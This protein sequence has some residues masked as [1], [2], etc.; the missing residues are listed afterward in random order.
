MDKK[1]VKLMLQSIRDTNAIGPKICDAEPGHSVIFIEEKKLV[2][3][4]N[5]GNFTLTKKG[6]RLLDGEL[7]WEDI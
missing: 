3:R 7:K 4:S 6:Q 5:D 1:T 2:D